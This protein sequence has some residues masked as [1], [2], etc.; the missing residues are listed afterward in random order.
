[1]SA[2]LERDPLDLRLALPAVAAWIVAWQAR[3]VAP[4]SVLLGA[5][6]GRA[7]CRERVYSSG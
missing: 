1:M 6:I 3:L 4:G 5:E 7:S 2:V